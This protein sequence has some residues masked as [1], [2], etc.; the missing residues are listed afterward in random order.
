MYLDEQMNHSVPSAHLI[1]FTENHTHHKATCGT[2]T[3]PN[4]LQ[5]VP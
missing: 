1:P 4:L 3:P 2:L 5:N